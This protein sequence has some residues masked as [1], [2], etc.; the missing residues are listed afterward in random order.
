MSSSLAEGYITS[1]NALLNIFKYLDLIAIAKLRKVSSSWRNFIDNEFRIWQKFVCTSDEIKPWRYQLIQTKYPSISSSDYDNLSN[2]QYKELFVSY[3][4]WRRVNNYDQSQVAFQNSAFFDDPKNAITLI[5][6]W[7]NYIAFVDGN[8]NSMVLVDINTGE[9]LMNLV[10]FNSQLFPPENSDEISQNVELSIRLLRIFKPAIDRL[11]F[12]IQTDSAVFFWDVNEKIPIPTPEI[13]RE[14][15]RQRPI[16]IS[17]G[18]D[19]NLYVTLYSLRRIDIVRCKFD[20]NSQSIVAQKIIIVN[21]PGNLN[22][23]VFKDIFFQ[24]TA[25]L[26]IYRHIKSS[27]LMQVNIPENLENPIEINGN[28]KKYIKTI[29]NNLDRPDFLYGLSI[30]NFNT[31]LAYYPTESRLDISLKLKSSGLNYSNFTEKSYILPSEFGRIVDL[32]FYMNNLYLLTEKDLLIIYKLKNVKHLIHL[33]LNNLQPKV[34]NISGL[35]TLNAWLATESNN[36]PFI[37]VSTY[38]KTKLQAVRVN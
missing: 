6:T 25:I 7:A 9:S 38:G 12:C 28:D 18:F 20:I 10:R 30:T 1:E 34:I 3:I 31:V 23:P 24:K 36:K 21:P 5:D 13:L 2:E 15:P 4:N 22:Y 33:Q 29:F 16:D 32:F 14:N 37:I 19:S 17:R 8:E 27:Y 11:F 26:M 35:R